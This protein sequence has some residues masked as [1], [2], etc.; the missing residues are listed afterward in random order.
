MNLLTDL[1]VLSMDSLRYFT[2]SSTVTAP[3]TAFW[4]LIPGR[5][6]ESPATSPIE[7]TVQGAY[8]LFEDVHIGLDISESFFNRG[9][10][11]HP[12]VFTDISN[13]Y[14][15]GSHKAKIQSSASQ[16]GSTSASTSA[17]SSSETEIATL[18]ARYQS[19]R[20]YLNSANVSNSNSTESTIDDAG[21][22]K[23]QDKSEAGR[24]SSEDIIS[25]YWPEVAAFEAEK[26]KKQQ[27]LNESDLSTDYRMN[28]NIVKV[29][30]IQ[31]DK[32]R[33]ILNLHDLLSVLTKLSED[34]SQPEVAIANRRTKWATSVV[35]ITAVPFSQQTCLF[36]EADVLIAVAGT[37]VHNILFMKPGAAVVGHFQI[38]RDIHCI[39]N[40]LFFS[41]LTAFVF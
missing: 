20:N 9:Y 25:K 34:G 30:L 40:N 21:V 18:S 37:A 4:P 23:N 26:L 33:A 41:M 2:S 12:C 39:S 3:G 15:A 14:G 19:F 36:A 10:D 13:M 31:R 35:E 29:L 6:T 38:I 28:V 8:I 24:C 16:A 5:R 32:N 11:L 22:S 27:G 1:P 7:E 17:A